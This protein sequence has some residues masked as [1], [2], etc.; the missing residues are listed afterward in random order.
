MGGRCR[1]CWL[2]RTRACRSPFDEV[3]YARLSG[4][5]L[6][7]CPF[8]LDHDQRGVVL[9]GHGGLLRRVWRRRPKAHR[10]AQKRKTPQSY[11]RI[12]PHKN[13]D[14][15][16]SNR[17]T[18]ADVTSLPMP[19]RSRAMPCPTTRA[20]SF[21]CVGYSLGNGHVTTPAHYSNGP[22]D[23]MRRA[24]SSITS[25]TALSPSSADGLTASR[26]HC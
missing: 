7:G 21:A 1:S 25:P 18:T 5:S 17:S 4:G 19:P 16:D 8:Y 26:N 10:L 12:L 3:T 14:R 6:R 22:P 13:H 2:L 23:A 20:H 15:G 9:V 11:S 24:N